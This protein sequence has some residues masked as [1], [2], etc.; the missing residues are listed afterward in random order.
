MKD[1][2]ELFIKSFPA[3]TAILLNVMIVVLTLYIVYRSGS[4][5]IVANKI[6]GIFIGEKQYFNE[7][8]AKIEQAEHDIA[9]F[10]FKTNL[11]FTTIKQIEDFYSQL[12]KFNLELKMYKGLRD[13]Y[14]PKNGKIK[15][16]SKGDILSVAVVSLL[17]GCF[18][19]PLFVGVFIFKPFWDFESGKLINLFVYT[20]LIAISTIFS[21]SELLRKIK[22]NRMRKVVYK[23]KKEY[24]R[25]KKP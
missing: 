25:N 17:I 4:M 21:F 20:F 15:K 23:I 16:S 8:L 19:L 10:N 18:L 3:I 14:N 6:W 7:K 2:F 5:A 1:S 11:K 22:A 13:A 24:M 12:E 9:K